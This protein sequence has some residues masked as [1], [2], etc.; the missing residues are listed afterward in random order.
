M[1]PVLGEN[2]NVNPKCFAVNPSTSITLIQTN[3]FPLFSGS[4]WPVLFFFSSHFVFHELFLESQPSYPYIK[5]A[6]THKQP[7][8][9]Q[10]FICLLS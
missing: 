5:M 6:F 4:C 3:I 2:S 8:V 9:S 10:I 1:D 7:I